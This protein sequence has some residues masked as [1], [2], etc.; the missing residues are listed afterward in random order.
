MEAPHVSNPTGKTLAVATKAVEQ[1]QRGGID[2]V[3]PLKGA[4]AIAAEA[5]AATD[6]DIEK[7]IARLIRTHARLA[8]SAGFITG[9]GGLITLPVAIPASVGSTYMLAARMT[10]AIA[11]LRGYDIKSDDVRSTVLITMLGSSGAEVLKD[12]GIQA[13]QK[14]VAAVLKKVPGTFFIRINKA[15][16]FRLVTKAGTKGVLNMTKIVPL[17][18]APIGAG[19]EVAS[20]RAIAVYAKRNFPVAD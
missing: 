19:M 5:L 2:G 18:G 15:V 17:V 1:I 16:G 4:E 3:G 6:G 8:G 20:I 7:A 11:H 12:V 13:G 10:A 9:V 14:S